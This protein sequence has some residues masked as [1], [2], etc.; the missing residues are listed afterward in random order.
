MITSST[1][2]LKVLGNSGDE[3]IATGF[4]D[5]ATKKTVDGIAYS[6]YTHTDAN[7][8]SNAE[9][10][11]Q[12]GVTLIGAQRGFVINGESAGDNSGY[13]QPFSQIPST[14]SH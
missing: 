14:G 1:N 8:D 9:F 4:N 6:I 2:V 12:K 11:I 5:S 3:V 13:H 10:W 7:T